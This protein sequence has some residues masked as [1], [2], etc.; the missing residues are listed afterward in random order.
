VFALVWIGA[1]HATGAPFPIWLSPIIVGLLAAIPLSVWG[2]RVTP[3]AGSSAPAC[4]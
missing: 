3:A 4:C 2:S 1:I